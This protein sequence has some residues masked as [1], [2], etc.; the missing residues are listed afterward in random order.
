MNP[1]Q[2]ISIYASCPPGLEP[3]LAEELRSLRIRFN[4]NFDNSE[5]INVEG[6]EPGGVEFKGT[7]EDVFRCNLHLRV[8]SRVVVRLGSFHA[9]AFSEL[10]KKA[11]RL[12]WEQFITPGENLHFKVTCHKSRLYHSDAVAE[13]VLGAANDHFSQGTNRVC[14]SEKT[15]PGQ[16]VLVRLDRDNCVI[17]IDSSGDLLHRR[18]YRL[19]AAKAP[20]RENLAAG[21]IRTCGWDG[22]IPLVD[23]F[24]GSGTFPIE[25][26]LIA[27]HIP[28]GLVRSFQ[29]TQWPIH[30]AETWLNMLQVA[31][32]G[33]IH[34]ETPIKGFDRDKGA[35]E[36]SRANAA[37]AGLLERITFQKQPISNLDSNDPPGWIITNPPYGVRVS[38]GKDLRDL[39]ARFG[40]IYRQRFSNWKLGV[41]SSD[42]V[43]ITNLGLGAPSRIV[44]L[45]NGGIPVQLSI[46]EQSP[47]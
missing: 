14:Q 47:Q 1:S 45:V 10:R 16:L 15:K 8:A 36:I 32:L 7:L 25:A 26:G 9:S 13:R 21:I 20:L 4:P 46:F 28:P 19:A 18:G 5:K 43:L 40:S 44:H 27:D 39:Y 33:L 3:A 34:S 30:Q 29:F 11:S 17:S 22:S 42:P 35:I 41:L 31:R 23:P 24:C 38:E 37:R 6:E 2:E 12:P